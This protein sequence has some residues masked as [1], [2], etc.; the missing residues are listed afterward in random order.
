VRRALCALA[1]ASCAAAC[2]AA[3]ARQAFMARLAREAG[4]PPLA[5][6]ELRLW[7]FSFRT[8]RNFVLRLRETPRG[9]QG[10]LVLWWSREFA[11]NP[12]WH[13]RNLRCARHRAKLELRLCRA[14]LSPEP[15]WTA[16]LGDLSAYDVWNLPGDAKPAPAPHLSA[17]VDS[18]VVEARRGGRSRSYAYG[19]PGEL[20]AERILGRAWS[21]VDQ[22]VRNFR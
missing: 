21:F 3:D 7:S 5:E 16:L 19:S 8:P 15:D 12:D 20:N 22:H 9:A 17:D 11:P 18:L 14:V 6:N 10:E 2:L 1:L 13:P 4:L